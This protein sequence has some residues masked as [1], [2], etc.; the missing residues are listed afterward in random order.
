M[1]T[2]RLTW[3]EP[4]ASAY[5]L[6]V[7]MHTSA[8]ETTVARTTATQV[9]TTCGRRWKRRTGTEFGASG[10]V[11]TLVELVR[12]DDERIPQI[13]RRQ[14]ISNIKLKLENALIA[15]LSAM[16]RGELSDKDLRMSITAIAKAASAAAASLDKLEGQ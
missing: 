8:V 3:A 13:L 1:D 14:N 11:W 10:D 9:I 16:R 4:G 12:A 2:D 5:I 15:G 7:G 6:T